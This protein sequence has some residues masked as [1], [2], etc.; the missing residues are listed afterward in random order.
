MAQLAGKKIAFLT[1]NQGAE[2]AVLTSPW[3]AV[4]DAGAEAEHLAPEAGDVQTVRHDT[5]KDAVVQASRA[6]RDASADEFD[7]LIVPGGTV[8]ADKLRVDEDATAFIKAFVGAKKPVAVICHGPWALI[9]AGVVDGK[10][11]TSYPSLQTD[12]RNAGA[13][14]VDEE[15]V[16]C[17]KEFDLV[18]SRSP[19]DLEAFNAKL[20]EVFAAH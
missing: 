19:K 4:H 15:A 1:S 16:H 6:V 3:A 7:A 12:L 17:P 11:L 9:N 20:I 14:W 2:N 10:K 8:N 18:T 13:E 5:D